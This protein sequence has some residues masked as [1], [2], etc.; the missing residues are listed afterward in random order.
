MYDERESEILNADEICKY[1]R[2]KKNLLYKYTKRK[3]GSR[4]PSFKMGKRLRF[5][6]TSVDKWIA[7]MERARKV[8]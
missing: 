3:K 7:D 4:I 1:L 5:K 2:I 8:K 6:K